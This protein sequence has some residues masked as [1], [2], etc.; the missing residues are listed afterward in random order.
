MIYQTAAALLLA[1]SV[2]AGTLGR[3]YSE[4]PTH[5]KYL[6]D[7]FK[8]EHGKSYATMDE[9]MTRF[10]MDIYML[11]LVHCV[12]IDSVLICPQAISLPI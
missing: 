12:I 4:D 6:F 3:L 2:S 1:A 9:E 5:Q 11:C 7:A 8:R 10:G